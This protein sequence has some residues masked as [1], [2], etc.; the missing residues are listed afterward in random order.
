MGTRDPGEV[1]RGG[2]SATEEA[3]PAHDDDPE[4][5]SLNHIQIKDCLNRIMEK[6][7]EL[8]SLDKVILIFT[9]T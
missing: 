1:N 9:A 3:N 7:R 6:E 4:A 2:N 8:D 5:D